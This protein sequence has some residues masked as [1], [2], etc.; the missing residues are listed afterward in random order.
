[1]AWSDGAAMS[2]A[3]DG[4]IGIRADSVEHAFQAWMA[5]RP[6]PQRT[7]GAMPAAVADMAKR[8]VPG[9]VLIFLDPFGGVI[10][11]TACRIRT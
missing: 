6:D 11:R 4:S 9:G 5:H 7:Q 8:L 10:A 3:R 2:D 1:M